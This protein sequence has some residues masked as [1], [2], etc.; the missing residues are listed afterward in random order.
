MNAFVY[1]QEPIEF[2][3]KVEVAGCLLEYDGKYLFLHRS[4]G[5]PLENTWLPPAGKMEKDETPLSGVLRETFEETGIN[6]DPAL[7]QFISKFYVKKTGLDYV[8]HLYYQKLT[9]LPKVCL[10]F[11]HQDYKWLSLEEALKMPLIEGCEEII[12]SFQL[13]IR[14]KSLPRQSFYFIR[15]GQTDANVD[16]QIKDIDLDRSLN[17]TGQLQA[18]K[19][20]NSILNLPIKTIC[21]SPTKRT[22]ETKNIIYNGIDVVE[23]EITDLRECSAILWERM[24]QVESGK[25]YYYCEELLSFFQS[26]E[27]GVS[28]SLSKDGPTVI[29]AHGGVYWALCYLLNIKSDSWKIDNC[30]AVYF[31]P[32]ENTYWNILKLSENITLNTPIINSE[33]EQ[34]S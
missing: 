29:I 15:H 13:L 7:L 17:S 25:G 32:S 9:K 21:Y 28:E 10:N 4:I 11:E 8:Y 30:E 23:Y 3:S 12:H 19:L 1:R 18:E 2:D 26:V 33:I 34:S 6:L 5:M 22:K 27:R 20:R 14:L 24:M 31:D 16:P